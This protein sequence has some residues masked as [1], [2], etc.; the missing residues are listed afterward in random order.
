M[1][2]LYLFWLVRWIG[3]KTASLIFPMRACDV[4]FNEKFLINVFIQ[5]EPNWLCWMLTNDICFKLG[6]KTKPGGHV[7]RVG[8]SLLIPN[9]MVRKRDIAWWQRT[10]E[11]THSM[12]QSAIALNFSIDSGLYYLQK[13]QRRMASLYSSCHMDHQSILFWKVNI[14]LKS[15][16]YF[17]KSSLQSR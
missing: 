9:A 8:C 14:I 13:A 16:Y 17:E 7:T 15:Q 11:E 5:L 2:L 1:L 4:N 6:L 12:S 3:P 10:L